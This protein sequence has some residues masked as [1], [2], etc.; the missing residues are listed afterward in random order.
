[1]VAR[2]QTAQPWHPVA[3]AVACVGMVL[4]GL[5]AHA[6]LPRRIASFAGLAMAA[7]AIGVSLRRTP[8]AALFGIPRLSRALAAWAAA[9]CALGCGLGV[10]FRM[11]V[12]GSYIPASLGSFVIVAVLIGAAEEL[13]YRGYVQGQ[14]ASLGRQRCFSDVRGGS[15]HPPRES[16]GSPRVQAAIGAAAAESRRA[17]C[18]TCAFVLGWPAAVAIAAAGHTLYKCGLFVFPPEG[19]AIDLAALACMTFFGGLAFGV[20]RHLSGGVLSPVLAHAVFDLLVYGD[21]MQA[22]WWVWG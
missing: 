1:M 5:F 2:P 6:G 11:H 14:L 21:R 15:P 16:A 18:E 17:R 7:G 10:L 9:G 19:A 22:P 8:S 12:D 3:A 4:F 13:L 20:L